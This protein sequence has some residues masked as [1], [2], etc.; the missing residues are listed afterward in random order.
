MSR[1]TL[2]FPN[3]HSLSCAIT[4]AWDTYY[5]VIAPTQIEL[6]IVAM[7][8]SM[9]TLQVMLVIMAPSILAVAWMVWRAT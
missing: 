1:G 5:D 7:E 4:L 2:W 8:Q 3:R 9:Q 6:P